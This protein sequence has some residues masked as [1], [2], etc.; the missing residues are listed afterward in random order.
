MYTYVQQLRYRFLLLPVTFFILMEW[1][2]SSVLWLH[3]EYLSQVDRQQF[4]QTTDS[5]VTG[6]SQPI[7]FWS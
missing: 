2:T 3:I 4:K 7:N 1:S 6:F 5:S